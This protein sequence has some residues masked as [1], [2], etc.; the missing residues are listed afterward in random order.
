MDL[1]DFFEKWGFFRTGSFTVRDYRTYRFKVTQQMVDETTS[2]IAT[3]NY[4]KP[5]E[6]ITLIED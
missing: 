3:K 6:D 5:A 2:Y 1:T 4:K